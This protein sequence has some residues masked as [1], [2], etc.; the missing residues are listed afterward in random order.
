MP[1]HRPPR[2]IPFNYTSADDRQAV[3]LL[4]GAEVW[5]RLEELRARRVTGR[6]ARLLMRFFG[7]VLIHRRNPF[8]L[9]ELADSGERRRRLF[10]NMEKD[11]ALVERNS[12]GEARV[13]EVL[14]TCRTL[15]A[16]FQR[17]DRGDAGP[18]PPAR[19]SSWGGSSGART[20]SSTRSR[21]SR[22]RPTRPTGGSTC[23]SR[24]SCRTRRGRSRRCSPP[25]AG[26]G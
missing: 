1:I 20:S 4:L 16:E 17:G 15:F 6:S 8:L 2:E 18:P 13:L 21:S 10:A 11:L 24:W 9:Q 7:E 22:T 12:G 5:T 14:A 26:S 23:P 19:E 25:S 3:T